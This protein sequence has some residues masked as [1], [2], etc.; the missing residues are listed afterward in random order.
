M[1]GIDETIL[2]I[3]RL[4]QGITGR[5]IPQTDS[6]YAPIPAE[7]DPSRQVEESM[8]RLLGLL[9]RPLPTSPPFSPPLTAQESPSELLICLDLPGTRREQ[10]EVAVQGNLLV[11]TG[12]RQ[13]PVS[14]GHQL[15]LA[16][17]PQG[18][19]YRVIPL[20]QGAR[21]AGMSA[22]LRDGVL[23]I[24]VPREIPQPSRGETIPVT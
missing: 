21:P 11:V 2:Q 6:P 10:V 19:F 13:S 7:K 9:G 12:V 18:R 22:Q 1:N 5:P 17:V 14:N 23:E 16:E 4:Y 8:E 15:R 24:R 20:P 3:E